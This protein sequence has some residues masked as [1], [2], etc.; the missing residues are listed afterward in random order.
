[1]KTQDVAITSAVRTAIGS[2]GC[3]LRDVPVV[4]LGSTVV[5]EVLRRNGLRPVPPRENVEFRPKLLPKGIIELEKFGSWDDSLKEIAVDEVI[6]GNVLQAGQGQNP[7]RQ[8][9][10]YG[11]LSKKGNAFT[12][13]KVCASGMKAI[14][15]AA[16]AIKAGD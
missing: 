13:N 5:H 3:A 8:A 11:G 15:L 7:A 9:A 16:Q 12:V 14:A 10:I 4:Q 1:M 2:F 6:M